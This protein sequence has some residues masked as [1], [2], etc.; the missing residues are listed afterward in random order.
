MHIKDNG[1]TVLSNRGLPGRLF[2]TELEAREW[3]LAEN[4][5]WWLYVRSPAGDRQVSSDYPP[6][7]NPMT[8]AWVTI[9]G[10]TLLA[11]LAMPAGAAI[12]H[13]ER[14]GPAWLEREIRHSVIA[15]G[16]GA[17]LS[18][19]A[20]VLSPEGVRNQNM[21]LIVLCVAGGGIAFMA[22]DILLDRL[23]SNSVFQCRQLPAI[24]V[25]GKA[26]WR[27]TRFLTHR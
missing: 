12:A 23:K 27:V 10:L 16:G 17:L 13:V 24:L 20:L 9:S 21:L 6:R 14:I 2:A 19:V 26:T 1:S 8:A 25:R 15:F 3:L 4:G 18:A 5:N 7:G 22:L 11:G